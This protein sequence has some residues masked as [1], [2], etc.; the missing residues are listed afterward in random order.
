MEFNDWFVFPLRACLHPG[1]C[2][3]QETLKYEQKSHDATFVLP[4]PITGILQT[5]HLK[6]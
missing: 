5:S 3:P 4:L 6:V 2:Q 1:P